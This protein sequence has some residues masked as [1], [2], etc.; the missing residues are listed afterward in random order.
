M[1]KVVVKR[2]NTA[3]AK[4]AVVGHIANGLKVADA[5]AR[6]GRTEKTYQGWM[7]NDKDFNARITRV[8]DELRGA[9]RPDVAAE[10]DAA[11]QLDFV[12]WRKRFIHRDTPWH[13]KVW[14]DALDGKTEYDI[15]AFAQGSVVVDIRDT[16]RMVINCPPNHGKTQTLIDYITYR[17][18]LD[19]NFRIGIISKR[20]EN[21]ADALYQIRQ[22]LTS[23]QFEELQ[24][25]Y[26]PPGGFRPEKG[27]GAF[28]ANKLF[29]AGRTSDQKDPN[30]EALGIGT[31]IYGRR[32][33]MVL[34]DDCI[35]GE[36]A[37][38]F[39]KQIRW[40]ETE[41]EN[42]V[43]NGNIVIIGTRLAAVDMYSQLR[44]DDRYISG[45]TPWSY[46]KM[47]M[48]LHYADDP[49]DW[50]TLW[51]LSSTPWDTA[52]DPKD[53]ETGL[54]IAWNG[55]A[56]AK[57]RGSKPPNVW[58]LVYQ[59]EDVPDDATFHPDCIKG[60]EDGRRMPGPL[61][62]GAWG[63]PP[64]GGEGMY[65]VAAIDPSV[66]G[67][68]F[69]V[70]GKID[71]ATGDRWIENAYVQNQPSVT[72]IKETMKAVV[73]EYG[74]QTFVVE[75][76]GFQ[77]FL[78]FDSEMIAWMNAHGC[79]MQD[80]LTGQQKHDPVFGVA[81]LAPLFGYRERRSGGGKYEFVQGSNKIQLPRVEGHAGM[82]ALTEELVTWRPHVR[83]TKLIQDG[84]MAL[85]MFDLQ[86][87]TLLGDTL[88]GAARQN[89][90][91][92]NRFM[93]SGRHRHQFRTTV[94]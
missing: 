60:S 44:V 41:V 47:P 18:C 22:R 8:R 9:P 70:V 19:P 3:D 20:K 40:L 79:R 23:N 76:N 78:A 88:A 16:K 80:H 28:G 26:A 87:R 74:V 24:A 13:H 30:V 36:N 10:R 15:P 32:F 54:Y 59:Q 90:E 84:P 94:I 11:R 4:S 57:V 75:K 37:H 33:N 38:D 91:R 35:V 58:S 86:A 29:L 52:D 12:T 6:V 68:A 1:A 82:I 5:M 65:T 93:M 81:S 71:R 85:W 51:P 43:K 31:Q 48:V 77:G 62:A 7:Y 14:I 73:L 39:E 55:P 53:P 67:D 34:M 50:V 92:R 89:H 61:K 25:A 27:E 69:I 72:W 49:K 63:H 66:E 2:L 56:C 17:L 45:Q 46:I 83:G 21:A 64:Q 42:R